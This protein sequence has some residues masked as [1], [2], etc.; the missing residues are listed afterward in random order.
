MT[1]FVTTRVFF[2]NWAL[3]PF[4]IDNDVIVC[5]ISKKFL[6]CVMRKAVYRP[7]NNF[8]QFWFIY[9]WSGSWTDNLRIRFLNLKTDKNLNFYD[10][11]LKIR[12]FCRT[13]ADLK[14]FWL[15]TMNEKLHCLSETNV[16]RNTW[17]K[18]F[19]LIIETLILIPSSFV[20]KK[21]QILLQTFYSFRYS[22]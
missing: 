22:N 17:F 13:F 16:M 8:E 20:F 2:K 12:T 3:L 10:W 18:T 6:R 21:F 5:K 7:I 19:I 9:R 14:Q 1:H 11:L 15:F 4:S